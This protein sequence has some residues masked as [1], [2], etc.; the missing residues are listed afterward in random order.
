VPGTGLF[1]GGVKLPLALA[2]LGFI[3]E[4]KF[5]GSSGVASGGAA[6]SGLNFLTIRQTVDEKLV[7]RLD[8]ARGCCLELREKLARNL[9]RGA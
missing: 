4:Y 9:A 2:E 1:V 5:G 6:G 7:G 8:A 3:D